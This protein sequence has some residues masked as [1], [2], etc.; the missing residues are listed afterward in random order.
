MFNCIDCER[1]ANDD[2]KLEFRIAGVDC[3]VCAVHT[4][5]SKTEIIYRGE[6]KSDRTQS[7][8]SAEIHIYAELCKYV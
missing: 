2:E 1:I 8:I 5:K 7:V 6:K 4:R 3:D